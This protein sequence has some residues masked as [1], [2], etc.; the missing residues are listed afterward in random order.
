MATTFVPAAT[1]SAR[2]PLG[3]KRR[4]ETWKNTKNSGHLRLNQ[5]PQV[6]HALRSDQKR[7]VEENT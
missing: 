5:L 7:N 1:G 6:A 3:P 4:K 2:T